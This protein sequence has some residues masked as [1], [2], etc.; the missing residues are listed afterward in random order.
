MYYAC[1]ITSPNPLEKDDICQTFSVP[2]INV[3]AG[4]EPDFLSCLPLC[5]TEK[6]F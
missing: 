5:A 2:I 4:L 6:L 1:I 3:A